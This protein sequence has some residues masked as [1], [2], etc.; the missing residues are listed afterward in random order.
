MMHRL[1][2]AASA[3]ALAASTPALAA[4]GRADCSAGVTSHAPVPVWQGTPP[5]MESWGGL[6]DVPVS[7][8]SS[9]DGNNLFNITAPTYEAYLPAPACATGAAVLVVPGGGFRLVAINHEGRD[10]ARWLAK[11][12]V[13]AFVL[14]YR[15]VQYENP[16][17]EQPVRRP[18]SQEVASQAGTAD[19]KETLRLIRAQAGRFGIDP[20][21]TGAIGF[22]AGGHIVST[23]GIDPVEDQRPAFVGNIYGAFFGA[24]FPQLPPANLPYP[25]GTP[26]EIWLRPAPTPAPGALPPFFMAMAQDDVAVSLGFRPMLEAFYEAG[27]LPETHLY[28]RGGHGFGMMDNGLTSDLFIDQFHAWMDALG[29]LDGSAATAS[30]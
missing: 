3:A 18:V 5:G 9:E 14:K 19:A 2:L 20:S 17:V 4:D 15:T 7:E 12:G 1:F 10:V 25:E 28:M 27:Y 13:A 26:E 8:S 21:R 11:H 24:E 29:M 16:S 23:L 6:L 30:D 22:S